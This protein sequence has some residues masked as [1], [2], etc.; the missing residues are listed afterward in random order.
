[1]GM[2]IGS[3]FPSEER[4]RERELEFTEITERAI[5]QIKTQPKHIPQN[6][7]RGSQRKHCTWQPTHTLIDKTF[8]SNTTKSLRSLIYKGDNLR[9]V[10][11]SVSSNYA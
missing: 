3:V 6:Q 7:E 1:M 2:R 11:L 8:E 5:Y 10:T 9:S 4:K